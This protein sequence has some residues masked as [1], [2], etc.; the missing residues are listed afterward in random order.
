MIPDIVLSPRMVLVL[1]GVEVAGAL[2]LLAV[3]VLALVLVVLV[4][5]GVEVLLEHQR[6]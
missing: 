4:L 1:G 2:V 5:D 3:M 6:A